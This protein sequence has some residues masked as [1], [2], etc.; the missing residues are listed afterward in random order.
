M[1]KVSRLNKSEF[2]IN[3]HQIEFIEETPDTIVKMFSGKKVIVSES[4]E[5]VLKLIIDYR[6]RI[7]LI[8]NETIF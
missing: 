1:I 2:F 7:G 3:P 6:R 8:G 5:E 4:I